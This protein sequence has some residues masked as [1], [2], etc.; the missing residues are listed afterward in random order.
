[1][2]VRIPLTLLGISQVFHLR[3]FIYMNKDIILE[4]FKNS[5]SKSDVAREMGW[6]VN[7]NGIRKV[8]NLINNYSIDISHFDRSRK[9]REKRKYKIIK[10]ECPVCGDEFETQKGHKREKTTCSYSCSNTHF[11][12]GKNN[13]RWDGRSYRGICFTYHKKECVVCGED[14]I[15]EVHHYDGNHD[16]NSKENLIPLCSTHHKYWHS[17]YRNLIKDI[18]DNYVKNFIENGNKTF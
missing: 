16:N 5:Y 17:R 12:S 1:M 3:L 13:G 6:H 2:W 7:G 8:N 18:V 15:V 11:R 10:K 4:I 14:K 9:Q